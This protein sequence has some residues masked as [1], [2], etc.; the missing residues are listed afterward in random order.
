VAVDGTA[1]DG[2]TV[3]VAVDGTA[4]DGTAVGTAVDGTAVGTT[5]GVS[6]V[7]VASTEPSKHAIAMHIAIQ[8]TLIISPSISLFLSDF[9][10]V[11]FL[12][13]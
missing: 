12:I 1:V 5:V 8:N 11:F 6:V 4:V 3:G 9:L 13:R 2:T 7:E 10:V